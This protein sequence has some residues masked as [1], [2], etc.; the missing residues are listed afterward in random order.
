MRCY[1]LRNDLRLFFLQLVEHPM[2]GK[3]Y[4]VMNN[5]SILFV[6]S[7]I[8][9]LVSS[10]SM[11]DAKN[12]TAFIQPTMN[13]S[14]GILDYF[15]LKKDAYWIYK[16][17]VK[18]MKV[19]SADVAEQEITWKMEVKRVFQRNA[20]VGYEMS[21]AP[22]DLAWYEIGKEPSQ[23]GII[24][25]GGKYYNVPYDTVIRLLNET[26]NLFG[27]VDENDIFLDV[28]LA[29]GKKFC[30]AVSMTRPDNMYCWNV[31]GGA[32]FDAKNIKGVDP[33]ADLW[34]Y[35]IINQTMPDVSMMYFVPGVGISHYVYRHHGTVSEVD[36]LLTEY[37]PG[38]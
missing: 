17:T 16:G 10:C 11:A 32:L 15:P 23:Y 5:K 3:R 30:G 33:S 26:D 4:V 1:S 13:P 8:V 27:L 24:Q 14:Q 22:W 18:W 25:A 28:P 19:N 29:G 31:G 6:F 12:D 35:P 20:I 37:H 21:G 36:V 38:E 7:F 9:W 34:E 2:S